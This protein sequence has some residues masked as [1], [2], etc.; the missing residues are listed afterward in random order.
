MKAQ[1]TIS[2]QI[3]GNYD[4]LK[5]M[6][7]EEK[8]NGNYNSFIL[9]YNS[10]KDAKNAIKTAYKALKNDGCRCRKSITNKELY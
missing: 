8:E 2:G 5:A 3:N 4:F 10:M 7:Y 9:H 6:P 1:I